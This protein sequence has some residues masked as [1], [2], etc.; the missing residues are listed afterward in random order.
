MQPSAQDDGLVCEIN[1]K[2]KLK[3]SWKNKIKR[4]FLRKSQI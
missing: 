4:E 2:I 1:Y 3:V